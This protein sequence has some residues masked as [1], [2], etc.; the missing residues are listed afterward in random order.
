M[1][2]SLRDLERYRVVATDGTI[3]NVVDFL[4]DDDHWTVRH[5]VVETGG[6]F[7]TGQR[8]LISPASF[9]SVDWATREFHLTLTRSKVRNSPRVDTDKPVS[10]QH[11]IDYY[12]YYG[13]PA[14]WDYSGTI[15]LSNYPGLTG[16][17]LTTELPRAA[18]DKTPRD[19]HLRSVNE[20]RGYHIQGTDE[21]IG[22]VADFVVDDETWKVGYLVVDTSNWW[23]G[24]RVLVAPERVRRISWDEHI[25][26]ID[27]SRYAIRNSPKWN[28]TAVISRE[29]ETELHK[30]YEK[31]VEPPD[32]S[33]ETVYNA[34]SLHAS[35]QRGQP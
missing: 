5:L 28:P 26:H 12:S 20:V 15:S 2:R 23:V 13:Y 24:E 9:A 10:R 21:A 11:E 35:S 4:V 31:P 32:G 8:V 29:Y 3:G 16:G 6:P 17:G 33:N 14:Y 25:V 1:L 18:S 22:H 34:K 27:L 19:I 7:S 30:H